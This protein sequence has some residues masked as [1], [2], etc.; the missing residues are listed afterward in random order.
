MDIL[1]FSRSCGSTFFLVIAIRN[2]VKAE[3]EFRGFLPGARSVRRARQ[4]M[5]QHLYILLGAGKAPDGGEPH[6]RLVAGAF[7]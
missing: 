5:R 1:W 3:A 7:E 6:K 4:Q 2:V